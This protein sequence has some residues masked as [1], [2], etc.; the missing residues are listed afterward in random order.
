MGRLIDL[1]EAEEKAKEAIDDRIE[2]WYDLS[3]YEEP[4]IESSDITQLGDLTIYVLEGHVD[5]EFKT[6]T[7]SSEEGR[8]LFTVKLDAESGKVLSIKQEEEE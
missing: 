5:I 4:V 1:K 2:D 6:E 3:S 8:I 7:F